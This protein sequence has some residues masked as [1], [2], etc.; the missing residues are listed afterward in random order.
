MRFTSGGCFHFYTYDLTF[1]RTNASVT[2]V[3]LE[4]VNSKAAYRDA[5][6]REIGK[7]ELSE[8]DLTGLDTLLTFYR[9]NM[10][11]RCTTRNKIRISQMRLGKVIA[12]EEFEDAS[13]KAQTVKE[14]L[15]IP[16][17]VRRLP[18]SP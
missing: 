9:T 5:R 14:I 1:T 2:A 6:K 11:A 3:E 8:T 12:A 17:L 16:L 10:A 15:T 13:C 18:H 4:W 7:L